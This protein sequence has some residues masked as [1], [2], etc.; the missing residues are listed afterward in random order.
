MS[1]HQ[2]LGGSTQAIYCYFHHHPE[3]GYHGHPMAYQRP[4][5]F[6]L[7]SLDRMINKMFW[8]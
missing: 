3:W 7:N 2:A 6:A 1:N 4:P 5:P 8:E